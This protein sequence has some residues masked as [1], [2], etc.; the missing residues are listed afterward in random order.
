MYRK[1]TLVALG[2]SALACGDDKPGS[3]ENSNIGA[4]CGGTI[5]CM[6]AADTCLDTQTLSGFGLATGGVVRYADGY[7]TSPCQAHSECGAG[8]KCPV[9]DALAHADIPEQYRSTANEILGTA[10]YCYQPCKTQGECRPRYQCNTIPAAL[11]GDSA[12]SFAAT[13]VL[14]SILEGSISTDK[15]CLPVPASAADAGIGSDAG[16]GTPGP[17]GS[18]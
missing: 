7:C 18:I 13:L 14:T 17:D 2:L 9:G 8:G 15:Y 12:A 11:T 16:S 1:L 4:A 10:S 5:E 6:G 3:N